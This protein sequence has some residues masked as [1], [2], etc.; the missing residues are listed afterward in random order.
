MVSYIKG[1]TQDKGIL[2]QDP[3][4]NIW[5]Q[6]GREWVRRRLHN[7]ELHNENLVFRINIQ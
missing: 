1:G 6:E 2:N 5:A 7:E 3:E 4:L